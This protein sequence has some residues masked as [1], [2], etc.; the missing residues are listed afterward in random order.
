MIIGWVFFFKTDAVMTTSEAEG[1]C[2]QGR[3][4]WKLPVTPDALGI[5][6]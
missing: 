3:K 6:V 5:S 1:V 4:P 2:S